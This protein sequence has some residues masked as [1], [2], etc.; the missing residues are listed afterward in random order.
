MAPIVTNVFNKHKIVITIKRDV[1]YGPTTFQG[2]GLRTLYTLMGAI[3]CA[4]MVQFF[5]TNTDLGHLLQT[6]YEILSM[7]LGLPDC[8]F[9]YDYKRY[10]ECTTSSWMKHL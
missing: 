6:S 10:L 9:H 7:E 5:R 1:L 4:L 8:P 2:M 3:Y